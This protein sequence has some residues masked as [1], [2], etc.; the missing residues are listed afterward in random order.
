MSILRL[1]N[2]SL[3]Y[4]STQVL[5]DVYLRLDPGERVGLIGKNGSGKTTLL[6]LLTGQI[7]PTNHLDMPSI[8]VMEQAL[9]YFPGAV[10]VVSH[11]RFFIDKLATRLLVFD[12]AGS[13]YNN[14]ALYNDR[15]N[16]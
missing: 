16:N 15:Q 12:G 11:D 7:E 2:V 6:R 3:R 5:R 4:E 1:Q 8:Q 9:I 13:V 14:V 10:I